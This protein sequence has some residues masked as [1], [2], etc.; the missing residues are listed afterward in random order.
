VI[1]IQ[2]NEHLAAQI[3]QQ[4]FVN[5]ITISIHFNEIQQA[6]ASVQKVRENA[7]TLFAAFLQFL[8]ST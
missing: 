3:F 2:W 8:D 5:V 4:N 7:H 1:Q 6:K